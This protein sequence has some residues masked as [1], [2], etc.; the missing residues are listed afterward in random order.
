MFPYF[1]ADIAYRKH[2]E[3][4]GRKVWGRELKGKASPTR[5]SWATQSG[6]EDLWHLWQSTFKQSRWFQASGGWE[7]EH[8][9]AQFSAPVHILTMCYSYNRS[10]GMVWCIWLIKS[11]EEEP[12]HY[13]SIFNLTKKSVRA[14]EKVTA[15]IFQPWKCPINIFP[16]SLCMEWLAHKPNGTRFSCSW[17]CIQRFG[18]F[19]LFEHK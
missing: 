8:L 18:F 4:F 3:Y 14:K 15:Q 13:N 12:T 9:R 1:A 10:Q 2:A 19:L 6:A 7:G 5:Y 11:E 16:T 17:T